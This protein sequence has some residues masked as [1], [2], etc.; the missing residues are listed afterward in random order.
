MDGLAKILDARLRQWRPETAAEARVRIEELIEVADS[1]A[2]DIV[3][4]RAVAQEVL[5]LLDEPGL[6]R[7]HPAARN[8]GDPPETP[9]RTRS[10]LG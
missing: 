6:V 10:L 1:D 2:L 9:V 3:Q 4:S 5:D 8:P 7:P